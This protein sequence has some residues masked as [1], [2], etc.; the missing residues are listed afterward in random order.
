MKKMKHDVPIR[1]VKVLILILM[2]VA[3]G[4]VWY[5]YYAA[6]AQVHYYRR[7]DWVVILLFG[8]LYYGFC[9]SYDAFHISISPISEIIYSQTLALIISDFI[10]YVVIWLLSLYMPNAVPLLITFGVQFLISVLWTFL[11][12]QWYFHNF[13]PGRTAVIYDLREG[14]ESLVGEYGMEKKFHIEKVLGVEECLEK[15]SVLDEMDTVFLSGI[16]SHERNIIL[17][18]CMY[19]D[20]QVYVIPRIGDVIMGGA[21]KVHMFHLPMLRI[22]RYRPIPEYTIAKR[23]FDILFSGIAIVIASPFML[24][25]AI[26]IK[27]DGGPAL[28]KQKRL[29]KDGKEFNVLKFRSMRVDAEKDGVARLSTGDKDD[30]ITPVGKIIRKIRFDELPQLFNI[31]RG[32]M[33]I[34]G[35]RPERPEIARQ[36]EE[37]MPE[38]RLRL[39]AKAGLTGYAQVYGKYNTTPYDKLLM[40]LTYIG[41]PSLWEDF[42]IC[43]TTVKILFMPESTEGVEEGQATAM[44][45]GHSKGRQ[46]D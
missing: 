19:Q 27:S 35:P 10:M 28:Y 44:G 22:D 45:N 25:T 29:T 8:I 9:R 36:Y 33:S 20:I 43:L 4:F 31:L 3:F 16:H 12:H 24:V 41:T 34:V 40:D 14:M 37:E 39:Q 6:R 42:K 1:L 5:G 15:L 32:D 7:G 17:K 38:F 46:A 18:Y 21:K 30:R 2:M 11:A 13:R 23:A 26:A